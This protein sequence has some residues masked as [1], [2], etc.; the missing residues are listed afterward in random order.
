M[1]APRAIRGN[2][3]HAFCSAFVS[4]N[5]RKR[6]KKR[7]RSTA[8]SVLFWTG[9]KRRKRSAKR[10]VARYI[11]LA[12]PT[13]GVFDCR[14]CQAPD[15][16]NEQIKVPPVIGVDHESFQYQADKRCVGGN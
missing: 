16:T 8:I 9:R 14:S 5:F 1:L 2:R 11:L 12:L 13:R 3:P 7:A 4:R 10:A 6:S 15:N